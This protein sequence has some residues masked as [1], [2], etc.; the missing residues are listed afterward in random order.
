M[1]ELNGQHTQVKLKVSALTTCWTSYFHIYRNSGP[2]EHEH[3]F[4][5]EDKYS[6][7]F[8]HQSSSLSA[9]VA[10]VVLPRSQGQRYSVLTCWTETF[11]LGPSAPALIW[12]RSSSLLSPADSAAALLN[13]WTPAVDASRNINWHEMRQPRLSTPA[14]SRVN[15]WVTLADLQHPKFLN[16]LFL[17]LLF[18]TVGLLS[19]SY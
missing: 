7:W 8:H 19:V 6:S 17:F 14:I 18:E 10:W 15:F 9:A 12:E 4:S 16:W 13:L 1:A 5:L 3:H 11:R 2:M